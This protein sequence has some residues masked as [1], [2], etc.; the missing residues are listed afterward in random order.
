MTIFVT[1]KFVTKMSRYPKSLT[2]FMPIYLYALIMPFFFL[3]SCLLYEPSHIC[4][5]MR[6]GGEEYFS[7]NIS[8]VAAIILVVMS[9]SRV[10]LF[11]LRK[12]MN[13]TLGWFGMWCVL[14]TVLTAAFVALYLV[15]FG[16]GEQGGFF[17]YLGHC[18]T[19]L[20]SIFIYPYVIL[21]LAYSYHD[22]K[23]GTPIEAG[24]RL[25]FY[26]SRHQLKFITSAGSVLFLEASENYII[27]HYEENG[28]EKKYQIRNAMKNVEP[29]CEKAGFVRAHRS[30]ILNPAHVKLIRKDPRGFYFA[31]LDLGSGDGIPVS[32]KYY[33]AVTSAL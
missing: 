29:L 7:F 33:D 17:L 5:L 3:I 26:D 8:I 18:T 23:I 30:F 28:I 6:T 22:A 1:P 12:S 9:L 19:T 16:H 11:L 31:D 25:K 27:I 13:M 21:T 20:G 14:E 4:E 2:H 32:R 15:L 24:D 10:V